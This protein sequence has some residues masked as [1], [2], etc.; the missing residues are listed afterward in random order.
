MLIFLVAMSAIAVMLFVES[1]Y[2]A[3]SRRARLQ[4]QTLPKS[5]SASRPRRH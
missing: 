5:H 1:Q 3:M 4:I 2:S